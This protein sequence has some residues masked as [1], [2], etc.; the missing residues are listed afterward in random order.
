ML[1]EDV[2]DAIPVPAWLRWANYGAAP[3][4]ALFAAL[5]LVSIVS[6][7]CHIARRT[8]IEAGANASEL[9][10]EYNNQ[11][12]PMIDL[13][14]QMRTDALPRYEG[15]IAG[16]DRQ[17]LRAAMGTDTLVAR[18]TALTDQGNSAYAQQV[19]AV[20]SALE[21]LA[22]P[23]VHGVACTEVGFSCIGP[24]FCSEVERL[25]PEI[26][27]HRS[28]RSREDWDALVALHACWSSK[29]RAR[30]GTGGVRV[31]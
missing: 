1:G 6:A 28:P 14:D 24:S 5:G 13:L 4:T 3:L 29:L 19:T 26:A 7:R 17:S 2:K 18:T 23:F 16:F 30:S 9:V 10:R 15:Q 12:T 27:A 21:T 25:Y 31:A 11:I 22:V 8:R 20:L